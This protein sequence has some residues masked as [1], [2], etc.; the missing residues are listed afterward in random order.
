M[1]MFIVRVELHGAA[2]GDDAYERL[3]G[4]MDR[5]RFSRIIA[6]NQGQRYH[7]PPA[8]YVTYGDVTCDFV[9]TLAK[10]A[11]EETGLAYTIFVSVAL[12]WCSCN[13]ARVN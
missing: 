6:D 11:A 13:L 7:L 9:R 3:H 2:H 5:K 4:A 1:A 8:E 12:T 10:Q